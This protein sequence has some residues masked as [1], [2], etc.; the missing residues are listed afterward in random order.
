ME[1][2][3]LWRCQRVRRVPD[4]LSEPPLCHI[5]LCLGKAN[6]MRFQTKTYLRSCTSD[7]RM[8]FMK[9]PWI[10]SPLIFPPSRCYTYR[11]QVPLNR[12][13]ILGTRSVD[14]H[15]DP[16]SCITFYFMIGSSQA[17]QTPRSTT[18]ECNVSEHV[19]CAFPYPDP[20]CSSDMV[21]HRFPQKRKAS[22]DERS[23]S[24]SQADSPKIPRGE[25]ETGRV[26]CE[27][28]GEGI[29]FR[30]DATGGFTLRHWN[31]HRQ[32]WYVA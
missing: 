3:K 22:D 15:A 24:G 6:P 23:S 8:L 4:F 10:H 28:C 18:P 19:V 17:A 1:A 13:H 7:P 30:D 25:Y 27:V 20:V 29:S 2:P 5:D 31:T 12:D 11:L 9:D 14:E 32:E 16:V 26:V 21:P